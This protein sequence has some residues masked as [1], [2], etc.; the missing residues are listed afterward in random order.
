[1][2]VRDKGGSANLQGFHEE[3]ER[4]DKVRLQR[5]GCL[6]FPLTPHAAAT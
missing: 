3:I 4:R 1:M 6:L 2:H 5:A